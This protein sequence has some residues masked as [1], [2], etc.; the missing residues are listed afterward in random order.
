MSV[1]YIFELDR[2]PEAEP[3]LTKILAREKKNTDAMFL[4]ARVYV[5]NTMIDEAVELY[6]R[7]EKEA[8]DPRSKKEAS[9]NRRALLEGVL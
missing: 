2:T 8:P 9:D 4:L 5:Y 3:L 6:E 1:L 7:I